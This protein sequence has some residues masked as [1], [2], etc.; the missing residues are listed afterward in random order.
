MTEMCLP[1]IPVGIGLLPCQKTK[2]EVF[3]SHF[4]LDPIPD[5]VLQERPNANA[6]HSMEKVIEAHSEWIDYK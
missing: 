5:K 2:Q 6:V 1:M 4:Q 3:W